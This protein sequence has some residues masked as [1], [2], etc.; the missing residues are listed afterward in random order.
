[1]SMRNV[2]QISRQDPKDAFPHELTNKEYLAINEKIMPLGFCLFIDP[3]RIQF[4]KKKSGNYVSVSD[5]KESK[6]FFSI[7]KQTEKE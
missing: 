3:L 4:F 1:M 7:R 5:K 2:C 6:R